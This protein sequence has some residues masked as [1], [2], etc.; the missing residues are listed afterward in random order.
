MALYRT[1]TQR[2]ANVVQDERIAGG[3]IKP[4]HLV[5]FYAASATVQKV[6]FHNV[7]STNASAIFAVEDELQGK[8][9]LDSYTAGDVVRIRTFNA[10]DLVVAWIKANETIAIG[11][12][13]ESAGDGNLQ[14]FTT[15]A[16][17]AGEVDTWI[18]TA[19]VALSGNTVDTLCLVRIR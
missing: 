18:A 19:E 7:A 12:K 10:G 15:D 14:V 11:T 8:D 13:L 6:R 2:C 5:E 4:G 3:T 1:I 9:L 16:P 17:S